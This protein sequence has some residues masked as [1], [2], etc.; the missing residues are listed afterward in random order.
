MCNLLLEINQRAPLGPTFWK[1]FPEFFPVVPCV[2]RQR[3]TPEE[4]G[5]SW[6][7]T[8]GTFPLTANF[9]G[10]SRRHADPNTVAITPIAHLD[11]LVVSGK[12][13]WICLSNGE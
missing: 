13:H 12:M 10:K 9:V 7:S 4:G 1:S 2:L 6:T 3:Q 5:W 11:W 8:D